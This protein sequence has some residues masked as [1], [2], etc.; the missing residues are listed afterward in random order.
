MHS[1][2]P[3]VPGGSIIGS[4]VGSGIAIQTARY[5]H[6]AISIAISVI[7]KQR[8]HS[9]QY[10]TPVPLS[11]EGYAHPGDRR[12]TFHTVDA[13]STLMPVGALPTPRSLDPGI[14]FIPPR[15]AHIRFPHPHPL[16][17]Q[18][19]LLWRSPDAPD[20]MRSSSGSALSTP[21][22]RKRSRKTLRRFDFHT[23]RRP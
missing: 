20:V 5:P 16:R 2:F 12:S 22:T 23:K 3:G 6:P 21:K 15:S 4:D 19:R 18:S 17:V 14:G 8:V 9:V 1:S 7:A 13:R 10:S 11:G